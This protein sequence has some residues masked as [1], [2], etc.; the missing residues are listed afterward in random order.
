MFHIHFNNQVI[1]CR[2]KWID[3]IVYFSRFEKHQNAR[4]FLDEF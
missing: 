4:I 2:K 1:A 3:S